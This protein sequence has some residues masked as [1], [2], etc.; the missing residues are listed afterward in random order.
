MPR[1][2]SALPSPRRSPRRTQGLALRLQPRDPLAWVQA[3]HQDVGAGVRIVRGEAGRGL[4]L[5]APRRGPGLPGGDVALFEVVERKPGEHA[6]A[7][8]QEEV[9]G[10][11]EHVAVVPRVSRPGRLQP[12]RECLVLPVER[13]PGHVAH[14]VVE[15]PAVVGRVPQHYTAPAELPEVPERVVR[16]GLPHRGRG[17]GVEARRED[18]EQA[19]ARLQRRLLLGEAPGAEAE[20]GV[21][22]ETGIV[23]DLQAQEPL[24]LVRE[25]FEVGVDL[26]LRIV[27]EVDTGDTQRQ[28]QPPA[29]LDDPLQLHFN[30]FIQRAP[31]ARCAAAPAPRP[32]PSRRGRGPG[33]PA[34]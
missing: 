10:S 26:H 29:T 3:E 21:D 27:G 12:G 9:V 33:A 7:A 17:R 25:G 16:L 32:R 1:L 18:R 2:P 13:H 34:P 23:L 28:R 22:V 19:P 24:S 5:L 6:L 31:R 30:H 20:R 4:V 14:Q 8:L 15:A 11:G